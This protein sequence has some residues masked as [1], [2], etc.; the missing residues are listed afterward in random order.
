MK[1]LAVVI[2]RFQPVHRYHVETLLRHA[3]DNYDHVL[4]LLGSAHRARDPK[5]PFTADER[6]AMLLAVWEQEFGD[7]DKKLTFGALKDYPYSDNRWI[8]KVQKLV[9]E[10]LRRLSQGSE[11]WT[12]TV[13][14]VDKDETTYYLSLFP[15]WEHNLVSAPSIETLGVGATEVRRLMFRGDV[16]ALSRLVHPSTFDYIQTW[17][18]TPEGIICREWFE[19]MEESRLVM[20]FKREDAEWARALTTPDEAAAR[21]LLSTLHKLGMNALLGRT[22]DQQFIVDAQAA[23]LTQAPYAPTFVTVDNVVT[24]R[25]HVLLI[26]RRAHPGKG[27]WAL[28]GGFLDPKEWIRRGAIRELME[29]TKIFFFKPGP[30][31][32]RVRLHLDPGWCHASHIF[33]NPGRSLRGRTITEAFSWTIPDEYEVS[34]EAAD[35]AAR[36]RWFPLYEALEKMDEVLFEDHQSIVAHMTLGAVR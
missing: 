21:A 3:H 22:E 10:E 14:G 26:Q 19:H 6:R 28:P 25:G 36:V 15:H 9:E 29:E 7:A 5:N 27:L 34:I 24:W 11:E 4:V 8:F 32:R 1:R 30:D 18:Q 20:A 23:P 35:D 33:D 31:Q 16:I 12:S 17:L 2:G 13:V